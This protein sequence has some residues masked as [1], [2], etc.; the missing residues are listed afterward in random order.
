M[1]EKHIKKIDLFIPDK[2][3]PRRDTKVIR[4][5]AKKADLK[6]Q[7]FVVYKPFS[8]FAKY[9]FNIHKKYFYK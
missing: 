3:L 5:T 2:I 4:Y 9:V 7:I 1:C 6:L 8:Y